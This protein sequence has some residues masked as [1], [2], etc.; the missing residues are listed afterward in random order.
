MTPFVI[1]I[2]LP[3]NIQ[4]PSPCRIAEVLMPRTSV[5]YPGSLMPMQ[6]IHCPLQTKGKILAF[7]PSDPLK[8]RLLTMSWAWAR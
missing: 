4:L 1:H 6:P 8:A 7:W 2:F 3:F 5:P